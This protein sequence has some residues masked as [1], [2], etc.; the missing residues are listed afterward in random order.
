MYFAIVD[1]ETSGSY[2]GAGSITEIAIRISD[3]QRVVEEYETLVNPG[4]A[5]PLFIQR[6]T[7]ITPALVAN[8]PRFDEVA[9][10]IFEL[11]QGNVFVAHS[12]NFDFSFVKRELEAAGYSLQPKKL[13]TIRLSRKIFPGLPSYS[14]GNLCDRLSIPHSQR[15]RAGGDANATA[16]LFHQ[17]VANDREGLILQSLKISSREQSLP[18]HIPYE[19]FAQLPEASGVYY[20]HDR[21][22]KVIYVGKAIN[23]RK[24]V[25]THFTGRSTTRQRQEFIRHI[26][27]ISFTRCATELM[28]HVFESHEIRRLW[29]R[30]NRSQKKFEQ[31]YGIYSYEDRNGYIRLAIEKMKGHVAPHIS[32]HY[33]MEGHSQLKKL[34]EEHGLCP[35]LCFIQHGPDPCVGIEA[36]HCRGACEQLEKPEGYNARIKIAIAAMENQASYLILD[37]GLK[38]NEQSCILVRNGCLHSMGYIPAKKKSLAADQL[39]KILEPVKENAYIRGLVIRY[40]AEH[41]EKVVWMQEPFN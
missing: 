6:L 35:R 8:A 23:I 18:P 13:C 37:E 3:G 28:A 2:A 33:L 5:I 11:L 32:F 7:G 34:V 24:R 29:P 17:L 12:V 21:S 10:R 27:R 4:Q 20:F 36:G 26:H 30:F 16:I 40:A 41:P 14:L 39:E 38:K 19:D 22:G 9:P 15:H 31:A 25:S 1:I